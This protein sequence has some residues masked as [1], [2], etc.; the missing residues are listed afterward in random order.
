MR[1]ITTLCINLHWVSIIK[2]VIK[3]FAFIFEKLTYLN[4]Q[5]ESELYGVINGH[6]CEIIKISY[7]LYNTENNL[8]EYIN[9]S[10]FNYIH[11][12]PKIRKLFKK[13]KNESKSFDYLDLRSKYC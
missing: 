10:D 1:T 4:P 8:N 2:P 9:L 11:I 13:Y 3:N 12:A 6:I 5:N 7:S